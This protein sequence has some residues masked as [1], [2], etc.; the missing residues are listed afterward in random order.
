LIAEL[1]TDNRAQQDI[2]LVGHEP[3][4]SRLLSMLLTGN[5]N[6]SVVMKKG[7]LC[8]LDLETLRFGRCARLNYLL[9]PRQLRRLA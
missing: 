8:T 9:T 5:P 1:R 4:L 2:M 3:Y 6:L 7:G